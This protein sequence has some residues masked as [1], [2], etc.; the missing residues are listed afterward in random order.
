MKKAYYIDTFSTQHLHE[1]YDASSLMMFSTMYD[2]IIYRASGSSV[3]HVTSL[4]GGKLPDNVCVQ[5]L[6]IIHSYGRFASLKR[7][8]KQLQAIIYNGWCILRA[9]NNTD[10]IIN[11]NTAA[12][13][14]IVNACAKIKNC[15]V[16]QICH[17]EMQDLVESRPTSRLFK[18]GLSLFSDK[19]A[20]VADNLWFAVLGEAIRSNLKGVV[21]EQV[22][23]K[24]LSFEHTAI[25]NKITPK[26]HIDSSKLVLGVT[27]GVRASK[28]LDSLMVLAERLK[29]NSEV[30]IRVIGSLSGFKKQLVEAGISIPDGIGDRFLSR[31]EM[32][33]QISQLDYAL[34]L[35]PREGYRFTASGSVF[36]AIDCERPIISLRNDYFDGMFKV[37]GDFGY[38]EENLDELVSRIERLALHKNEVQ[39]N[40]KEVKKKLQPESAAERF[41]K[42]WY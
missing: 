36:D 29:N 15:R 9:E 41:S 25:F 38:L 40:V 32:Y 37:C 11:Y 16:L 33:D 30:E 35:F 13:L 42:V 4:L 10:V 2:E 34:Y 3:A 20:R 28:G 12:A 23:N 39:W 7:L 22:M 18:W 24:M 27:G 1:M 6:P 17:G 19:N 5:E 8:Y 21:T 26:K 14:R 31:Q